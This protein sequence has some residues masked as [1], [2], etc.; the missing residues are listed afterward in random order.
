MNKDI[1]LKALRKLAKENNVGFHQ[2]GEHIEVILIG[3]EHN[4]PYLVFQEKVI[5][6]VK[7]KIIFHEAAHNSLI[8]KHKYEGHK[9]YWERIMSWE[10]KYGVPVLCPD[11]EDKAPLRD[12][13]EKFVEARG[14][15]KV[16]DKTLLVDHISHA[17]R[18][19]VMAEIIIEKLKNKVY[20]LVIIVG[21]A[22]AL[23]YRT[24]AK[25][26]K[27]QGI[28]FINLGQSEGSLRHLREMSNY[29]S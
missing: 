2:E 14:V 13:I 28:S 19:S 3:E 12:S 22:H 7:P 17:I 18:E 8:V 29:Y 23:P 1:N 26:L 6:L 15:S 10:K 5:E 20:P 25:I 9:E 11:I 27:K 16:V 24:L 21:S 4:E